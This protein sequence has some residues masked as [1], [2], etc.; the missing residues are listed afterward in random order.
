[1]YKRFTLVVS[2]LLALPVHASPIF[3]DGFESGEPGQ[4]IDP[5]LATAPPAGW[6]LKSKSWQA[7]FSAPN[8]SATAEY[9]N[10]VGSPVPIPGFEVWRPTGSR[11]Y[12]KGQ[13]LAIGFVATA[14]TTVEMTW[15]VAQANQPYGYGLPRPAFAMAVKVSQCPWDVTPDPRCLRVSGLDTLVYSTR[16]ASGSACRIKAGQ[17][18][19]INVVMADPRNGLQAG[20]H[21]CHDTPRSAA[22]CDVQ[23][24]HTGD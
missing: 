10:S 14:E 17:Q 11:Y 20:E 1:M 19:F 18:Y 4:P 3:A 21:T 16:E 6:V 2:L 8:G 24:R 22:G 23:M 5:C 9:P 13:I 7:A 15:D 12:L